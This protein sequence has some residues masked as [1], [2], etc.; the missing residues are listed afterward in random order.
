MR[1]SSPFP[2]HL[3]VAITA[4]VAAKETVSGAGS[5]SVG[6]VRDSGYLDFKTD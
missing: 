2:A 1:D 6:E 3:L 4:V 5:A